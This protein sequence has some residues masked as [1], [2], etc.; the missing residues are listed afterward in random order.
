MKLQKE[1][2][3]SDFDTLNSKE[4]L[5][6]LIS[7]YFGS[8]ED[9]GS[10]PI[11]FRDLDYF[12]RSKY[13]Y[14]SYYSFD[15]PK[16]SGGFR[17]IHAPVNKLRAI[18]KILNNAFKVVFEFH[19]AATGFI[20]N[21]SIVDNAQRHVGKSYILNIDLQDFFHSFERSQLKTFFMGYP[22]YLNGNREPIAYMLSC[23]CTYPIEMNDQI[24]Y[25]LPQ[26]SPVSPTLTN[27][28]S[29]RLD[30]K[31]TGIAKRFNLIYSRYADDI[32]FSGEYDFIENQDFIQELKRII[33]DGQGKK[34]NDSKTRYQTYN[35]RQEVTGLIVNSKVNVNRKYVKQLRMWLYYWE[36]YGYSKAESL[37]KSDYLKEKGHVK[38]PNSKMENV[39]SGKLDF[40]KMV[41]GKTD[42]TYLGL[43]NRYNK[44]MTDK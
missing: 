28:L 29:E 44:L 25:V 7:K 24:K 12:S 16:K 20:L 27:I 13:S 17:K 38:N 5:A 14:K 10:H 19:D 40:L 31:L 9:E 42:L 22:F 8:K 36:K 33:E 18:Q 43:L 35:D 32:T 23:L 4:D 1:A 39:L 6:T 2:I 34:I 37:F 21:R 11:Q 41:K 30:K 26:G 3:I 15:L